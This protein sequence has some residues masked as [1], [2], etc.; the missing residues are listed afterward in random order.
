MPFLNSHHHTPDNNYN[1]SKVKSNFYIILFLNMPLKHMDS[2]ASCDKTSHFNGT[3]FPNSCLKPSRKCSP[4][5]H[6]YLHQLTIGITSYTSRHAHLLSL[7]LSSKKMTI[8][9]SMLFTTLANNS[10]ELLSNIATMQNWI[11]QLSIYPKNTT[12]SSYSMK[13]KW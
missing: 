11:S 1:A 12:T 2:Y 9:R 6:S 3:S 4:L 13:H 5:P 7:V 8:D 10:L